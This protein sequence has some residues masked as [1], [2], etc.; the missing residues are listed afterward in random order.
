MRTRNCSCDVDRRTYGPAARQGGVAPRRAVPCGVSS[1]VGG[2]PRRNPDG[3]ST[4]YR[5]SSSRA[6]SPARRLHAN[7]RVS[8]HEAARNLVLDSAAARGT[9]DDR[10]AHPT[11]ELIHWTSASARF[12][13]TVVGPFAPYLNVV[14]GRTKPARPRS[15][16]S[17]AA[18]CSAGKR[19]AA[20]ATPTSPRMPSE[21]AHCSSRGRRGRTGA[22]AREDEETFVLSRARNSDGLQGDASWKTSTRTPITRCSP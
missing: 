15:R 8:S 14:L 21:P 13:H 9:T 16:R 20:A 22:S 4:F 2:A 1:H 6:T 17:W 5:K 10:A 19:R 3:P 7:K 12:S 18:C 11:F